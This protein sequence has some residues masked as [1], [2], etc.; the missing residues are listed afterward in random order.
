MLAEQILVR[1]PLFSKFATEL[2][3]GYFMYGSFTGN[4]D[5][6]DADLYQQQRLADANAL[7]PIIGLP[8]S[9]WGLFFNLKNVSQRVQYEEERKRK[10]KH[11]TL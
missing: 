10:W 7:S 2:E 4:I 5:I 9:M 8:Y 1:G 6:Y 11:E 3:V